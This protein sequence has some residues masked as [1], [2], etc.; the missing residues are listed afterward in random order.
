MKTERQALLRPHFLRDICNCKSF[1]AIQ[2]NIKTVIFWRIFRG[3]A[4]L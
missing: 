2:E 4:R 1:K 3:A